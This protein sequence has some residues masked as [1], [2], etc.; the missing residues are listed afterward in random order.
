MNQNKYLKENILMINDIQTKIIAKDKDDVSL[1]IKVTIENLT[2]EIEDS[3]EFQALDK[4]GFEVTSITLFSNVYPNKIK[5][6]TTKEYID[7]DLF[8]QIV[9]WTFKE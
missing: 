7:N 6:L 1:A 3:F 9:K 2:N 5:T 8:K 4:D